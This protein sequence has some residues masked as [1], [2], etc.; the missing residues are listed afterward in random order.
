LHEI[1]LIEEIVPQGQGT[2]AIYEFINRIRANHRVYAHLYTERS[3]SIMISYDEL[4]EFRKLWL[5]TALNL[6]SK[7]LRKLHKLSAAQK[8]VINKA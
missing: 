7:D 5:D 3:K 2:K 6:S 8:L 4:D 1:G